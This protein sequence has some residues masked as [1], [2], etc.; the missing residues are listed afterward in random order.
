MKSPILVGASVLAPIGVAATA[1]LAQSALPSFQGDP[2]VY[3]VIF[4]D[5]NF[6]V[7]TAPLPLVRVARCRRLVGP[8]QPKL[9]TQMADE[10]ESWSGWP[11]HSM[12]RARYGPC[13]LSRHPQS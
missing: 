4:E 2:D 6:R 7:I 5:Q 11:N 9:S 8:Y 1:V 12:I 3:K 13:P 10:N